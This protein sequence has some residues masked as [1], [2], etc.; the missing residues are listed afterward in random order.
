M[1]TLIVDLYLDSNDYV[2]ITCNDPIGAALHST[3]AI[4]QAQADPGRP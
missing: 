2:N 3:V 1:I 4:M